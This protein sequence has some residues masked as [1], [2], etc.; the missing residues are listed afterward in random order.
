MATKLLFEDDEK[1]PISML[2]NNCYNGGNIFFSGGCDKLLNKALAIQNPGDKIIIYYDVAPNNVKTVKG[3]RDLYKTIKSKNIKDI[4]VVPIIC[5]EY[6]VVKYLYKYKQLSIPDSYKD[7]EKYLIKNLNWNY[8]VNNCKTNTYIESSIEHFYKIVLSQ[9]QRQRC[10]RNSHKY[11][12]DGRTIDKSYGSGKFF[13]ENCPCNRHCNLNCKDK[14]QLKAERLYMELP[15][16]IINDNVHK[17]NIEKL[18]IRLVQKK[19]I[20]VQNERQSF[21]DNLCNNMGVNSIKIKLL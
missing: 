16:A 14:L 6:I 20:D 8:Y 19:L 21:Y 5:I 11:S 13:Y 2:L 10:K 15:L 7:V 4:I 9:I 3:Y 17:E 18:G 1:V 12:K